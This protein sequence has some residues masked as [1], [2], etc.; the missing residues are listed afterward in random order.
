MPCGGYTRDF[1]SKVIRNALSLSTKNVIQYTIH[2]IILSSFPPV[3]PPPLLVGTVSMAMVRMVG[4]V[5]LHLHYNGHHVIMILP[6][7]LL[8]AVQFSIKLCH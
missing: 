5:T 7:F 4:M 2:S 8:F 6:A 3:S 1:R